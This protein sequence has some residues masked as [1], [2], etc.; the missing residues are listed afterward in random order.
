MPVK[1]HL[2]YDAY[3]GKHFQLLPDAAVLHSNV[4]ARWNGTIMEV[5]RHPPIE[6]P[7]HYLS[8][9]SLT[10]ALSPVAAEWWG[11][12]RFRSGQ[13]DAGA[14]H[15]FPPQTRLQYTTFAPVDFAQLIIPPAFMERVAYE[16]VNMRRLTCPPRYLQHD[17]HVHYLVFAL[18]AELEA[19]QP[20]GRIFGESL[21]TALAV[22]LLRHYSEQP[23]AMRDVRGGLPDATLRRVTD[24]LH[25]YHARNL[26]LTELAAL[27]AISPHYFTRLFRQST[28]VTPHQ[29]LIRCRIERAQTLLREG[30]LTIGQIAQEVGFADQS[31]FTRHFR[32]TV[33][34][35]P[36]RFVR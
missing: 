2:L 20:N 24:Y 3:G 13:F 25:T 6:A 23:Q 18:K 31:H 15:L 32:R 10:V 17:A 26:T 34:V 28:G 9:Y 29:Y 22:H 35:T 16:T 21:T 27:A 19:G 8:G 36:A 4:G 11:G 12:E 1:K 5:I 30:R 7:E 33:G 14:F